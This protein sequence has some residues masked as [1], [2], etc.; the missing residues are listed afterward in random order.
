ML[1][2]ESTLYSVPFYNLPLQPT[3][4]ASPP[5]PYPQFIA[6]TVWTR[7]NMDEE[8]LH[9]VC[10]CGWHVRGG[11]PILFP[12]ELC[13]SSCGGPARDTS[14]NYEAGMCTHVLGKPTLS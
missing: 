12:V 7:V 1:P 8:K 11:F 9:K 13:K 14:I 6:A 2:D 3:F 5:L 10:V 4:C